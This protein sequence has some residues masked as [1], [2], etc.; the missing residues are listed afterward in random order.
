MPSIRDLGR[1][2][3]EALD[4]GDGVADGRDALE[5]GVGDLDVE[6]VLE[7]LDELDEVERVDV[8]LLP[9]GVGLRGLG[10][11]DLDRRQLGADRLE[12]LLLGGHGACFSYGFVVR[13]EVGGVR[14]P[15][16]RRRRGSPR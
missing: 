8:E 14:R 1:R 12:D 7:R 13:G 16:R 2:A 5:V 6:A 11:R 4:E 9:R 10:V 3:L 15:G